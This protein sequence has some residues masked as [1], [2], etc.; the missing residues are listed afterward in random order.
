MD[1]TPRAQPAAP[2]AAPGSTRGIGDRTI[3][4]AAWMFGRTMLARVISLVAMA[5]LARQL[6][7]E[8]F[9]LAALAQA[10]LLWMTASGESGITAY[11][12][13]S[14]AEDVERQAHSAFWLQAVITAALATVAICAIPLLERLYPGESL[15]LLLLALVVVFVLR[16][17]AAVPEGLIA[18]AIRHKVLALRDSALDVAT[19]ALSVGLA[20]AGYG[21]WSLILPYVVVQPVRLVLTMHL[22]RWRPGLRADTR[23][24]RPMLRFSSHVLA[25]NYLSLAINE[26]D[27]LLIGRLL[28]TA[29]LGL[30]NMAWQ[31]SNIIGRTITSVVAS[32]SLP[33]LALLKAEPDR[34]QA[35]YIRLLGV[36][37]AL[38]LPALCGLFAVADDVVRLVYGPKWA[39]SVPILRALIVFTAVRACTSPAG[40][41]F[42]L[43]GKPQLG[44]KLNLAVAPVYLAAIVAGSRWGI[45]GVAIAVT[46]VRTAGGLAAF[47]MS[48]R[49]IGGGVAPAALRVGSILLIAAGMATIV[50]GAGTLLRHTAVP[51]PLRLA[52]LVALGA[53][54]YAVALARLAAPTFA[55]IVRIGLH[56]MPASVRHR[57]IDRRGPAPA[58]V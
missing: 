27:T 42:A 47:V 32:M 35:S 56:V 33:A 39:A 36:L 13:V 38:V 58:I 30:Y 8:M 31:L 53:A 37:A 23:L 51:L 50:A 54:V 6:T 34:L 5:I 16:S 44:T 24:W 43:A 18:R 26:G 21:V 9:G 2:A 28:G 52:L 7:P 15:R 45:L 11:I 25:T 55:E 20:L 48:I 49:A 41:L 4:G 10:L 17:M 3:S 19:A 14:D 29:S 40:N 46:V 12:I 1:P 22:S 57:F